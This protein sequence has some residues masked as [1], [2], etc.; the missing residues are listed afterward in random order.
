MVCGYE[1]GKRR[2]RR[3]N[4]PGATGDASGLLQDNG[5]SVQQED[6]AEDRR[7]SGVKIESQ[8]PR[9][10]Q[11]TSAAAVVTELAAKA[12]PHTQPSPLLLAA[13]PASH[14]FITLLISAVE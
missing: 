13:T 12:P 2:R 7:V 5:R 3:R 10:L 1:R 9:W 6:L 8:C 14:L 4:N 11:E